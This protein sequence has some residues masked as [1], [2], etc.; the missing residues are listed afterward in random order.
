MLLTSGQPCFFFGA[1]AFILGLIVGLMIGLA[2]SSAGLM[3]LEITISL[4]R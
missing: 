4:L 1:V 2:I 3:T